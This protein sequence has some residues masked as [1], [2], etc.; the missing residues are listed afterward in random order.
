MQFTLYGKCATL[1]EQ[2]VYVFYSIIRDD[3]RVYFVLSI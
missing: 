3:A 1:N 2:K